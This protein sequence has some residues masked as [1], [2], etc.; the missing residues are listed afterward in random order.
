MDL[1][2]IIE[3]ITVMGGRAWRGN[4]LSR[5]LV[6][7]VPG[8]RTAYPRLWRFTSRLPWSSVAGIITAAPIVGDVTIIFQRSVDVG[9][10]ELA[11][12]ILSE[13]GISISVSGD[14]S[15]IR[16]SKTSNLDL[17]VVCPKGYF[18]TG[19]P[20]L[21]A[22]LGE[23]KA[24]GL[25]RALG[26]EEEVLNIL[27]TAGL[28]VSRECSNKE[29]AVKAWWS[30]ESR[31]LVWN[32]SKREYVLPLLLAIASVMGSSV[33]VSGISKRSWPLLDKLED[34]MQKFGIKAVMEENRL[35]VIGVDKPEE[36]IYCPAG[37]EEF[38][39]AL[40]LGLFVRSEKDVV[41]ELAENPS[42]ILP[43]F[44]ESLWSIGVELEVSG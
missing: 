8:S 17:E 27:S 20:T 4:M 13:N 31:G 32:I 23:I 35:F 16:V 3:A 11:S 43:G 26:G 24:Q 7:E 38:C 37:M 18:E 33:T 41:I 36:R 42:R 10:I 29:C 28:A 9:V 14:F 19:L 44:T 6:V 1:R 39:L 34:L 12:S 15:R 21:L 5:L 30:G 2:G 40:R 22:R 25:P